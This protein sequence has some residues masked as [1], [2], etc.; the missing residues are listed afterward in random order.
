MVTGVAP[1]DWRYVG[2]EAEFLYALPLPTDARRIRPV[3]RVR[4]RD[5]LPFLGRLEAEG[6]FAVD[7]V[8]DY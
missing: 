3:L 8:Y 2:P 5:L 4:T 7:H 6:R 1:A